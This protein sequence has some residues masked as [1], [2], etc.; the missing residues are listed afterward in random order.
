MTLHPLALAVRSALLLSIAGAAHAAA[1]EAPLDDAPVSVVEIRG[2]KDDSASYGAK[3]ASTATRFKLSLRETPQSV[4]VV[5]RQ[6][7]DDMNLT[8]I[9]DVLVQT[10]GITV[11]ENDTERTGF[12]S[13]GFSISNFQVDGVAAN[14]SS[15]NSALFDTA[16]YERIEVVRGATGLVTGAGD[17]SATINM[18]HKRPTRQLSGSASVSAGSWDTRRV[19]AD[20]SAPL[21][22]AGTVRGSLIGVVQNRHSYLDLYKERK[23][24]AGVLVEA[25]LGKDS[26]LTVGADYQHNTPKGT[27]WGTTP[28]YFS[29]GSL[30]KLPR[31]FNVAAEWS[32]WERTYRNVYANLEHRI[33]DDWKVK[34][35][36]N[37]L[38]STSDGALFYG[39]SGYPNRDGSGL[40]VWTNVFPYEETQDNLDLY[41]TGEFNL[42]GRKHELV[43]GWNGWR[44]EGVSPAVQLQDPLPFPLTI[45]DYRN[46]TGKVPQPASWRT[47]A[48]STAVTEQSG[49]YLAARLRLADPLQVIAGARLSTW[50][51][52]TDNVNTKGEFVN[53]TARYASKDVLTPYAGVVF[54]LA[55]NTS[56]YASYSDLFKPQ[57]YKDKDNN[58]LDPVTGSNVEA[59]VKAEFFGGRLNAAVAVFE[60]KQ[61]NLGEEDTSVPQG[62]LLPDGTRPYISTGKGTK[63]RGVEA[64]VSGS[65]MTGWQLSAGVTRSTS[66][67]AKDVL[68]NTTQP[69]DMVRITTTWRLPGEWRDVTIGGG[70]NWQSETYT[71]ATGPAGKL[72]ASQSAYT[73]LNLMGRYQITRQLSA[74][75]NVNNLLDKTYYRRIGF[76][77]GGYYGEPRSVSASLRY[78]Y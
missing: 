52:R 10:P 38:D 20:I 70:V 50:K 28:L 40:G 35:S 56:L 53:A 23:I 72:R 76:Y 78:Q 9:A 65:P 37:R 27:T 54:D 61:D 58:F 18:V 41:A 71:T 74:G 2:D 55:P 12:S 39:G 44:R 73:L 77:N 66:R 26:L 17:P 67:N 6:R 5:T 16:L 68:V 64:E 48:S 29:D 49:A 57:N 45:A 62:V 7:M 8:S 32:S 3:A 69:R 46:W 30:A 11:Q 21:N 60:A 31:S 47:G 51:T 63:S 22:A 15:G 43:A 4:T 36:Y 33:N 34:V 75:V 59:G 19:Q 42:F 14:Y 25:D 24:V 13:R 1:P